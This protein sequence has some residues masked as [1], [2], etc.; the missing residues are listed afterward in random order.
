M[1]FLWLFLWM[2]MIAMVVGMIAG[3]VWAYRH[4]SWNHYNNNVVKK[5]QAVLKE[6][7]TNQ[8]EQ[9]ELTKEL[10]NSE[11]YPYVR[12]EEGNVIPKH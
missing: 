10:N 12:D 9:D 1:A 11:W 4:W 7:L 2:C 6:L 3:L 5:K 8:E